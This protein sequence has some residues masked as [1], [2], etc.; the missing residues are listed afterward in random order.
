MSC[1]WASIFYWTASD[2]FHP[3][4]FM[5]KFYPLWWHPK[6]AQHTSCAVTELKCLENKT[7]FFFWVTSKWLKVSVESWTRSGAF[8]SRGST[9][10][11]PYQSWHV[12]GFDLGFG[13]C[14]FCSNYQL[15]FGVFT[16]SDL[17]QKPSRPPCRRRDVLWGF[18]SVCFWLNC[19]A[20][21][22]DY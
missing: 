4:S 8:R 12:E 15:R 11:E 6:N 22:H 20:L 9:A 16:S 2:H 3:V 10:I 18:F 13:D 1:C 21:P 19:Q 7:R 17:W 14:A 5:V